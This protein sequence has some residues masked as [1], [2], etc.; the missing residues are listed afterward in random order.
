MQSEL[1][2]PPELPPRR[3]RITVSPTRAKLDVSQE[4]EVVQQPSEGNPGAAPRR[5]VIKQQVF[6]GS[7]STV[8]TLGGGTAAAGSSGS[9]LERIGQLTAAG[10]MR[11]QQQQQYLGQAP[12]VEFGDDDSPRV[13]Q[14]PSSSHNQ[15]EQQRRG[16]SGKR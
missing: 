8:G 11:Q 9:G 6:T 2:P 3:F 14:I 12:R 13:E 1:T 16:G 10:R 4:V 5:F 7:T 15:Q